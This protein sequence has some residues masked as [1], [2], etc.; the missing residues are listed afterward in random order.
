MVGG[1]LYRGGGPVL[2]L[3]YY[4]QECELVHQAHASDRRAGR[5]YNNPNYTNTLCHVTCRPGRLI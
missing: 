3:L 4:F 1:E 5:D 2:P